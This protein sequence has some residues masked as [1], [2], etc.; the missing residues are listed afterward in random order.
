VGIE[1]DLY[2]RVRYAG[3]SCAHD[4]LMRATRP[5]APNADHGALDAADAF[6]E[7]SLAHLQRWFETWRLPSLC[8]GTHTVGEPVDD[9]SGETYVDDP[10]FRWV[11][12]D[13]GPAFFLTD[14]GRGGDLREA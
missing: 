9:E 2:R 8:S 7:G 11:E 1:T 4:L 6:A 14:S 13:G 10:G 3:N 5:S 12:V